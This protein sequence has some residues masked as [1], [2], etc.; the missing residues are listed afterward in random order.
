MAK[1]ENDSFSIKD[2]LGSYIKEGSLK[3][4]FQKIHISEAWTKL[5][6]AGVTSYTTEVRLQNGTLI[7]RLSSSVLREE[8]NYGKDKIIKMMNEEMGENLVKKLMLV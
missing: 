3:K 7:V 2:L 4:G 5:M 8:L 6:G 1:R